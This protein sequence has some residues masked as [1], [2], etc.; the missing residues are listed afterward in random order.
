MSSMLLGLGLFLC[1]SVYIVT[2]ESSLS[3]YCKVTTGDG[4]VH[5]PASGVGFDDAPRGMAVRASDGLLFETRDTPR[6][7]ALR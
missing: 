4:I 3:Q 5:D 1:S 6:V 2:P 7:S